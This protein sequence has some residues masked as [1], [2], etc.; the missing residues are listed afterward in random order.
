VPENFSS[1][2][3]VLAAEGRGLARPA[4]AGVIETYGRA[5][6]RRRRQLAAATSGLAVCAVATVVAVGF[7]GTRSTKPAPVVPGPVPTSQPSTISKINQDT[8]RFL[9]GSEAPD[10]GAYQWRLGAVRSDHATDT[11][12]PICLSG[13]GGQA[14]Q[15][16]HSQSEDL[17][18][19]SSDKSSSKAYES[20]FHYGSAAAARQDYNLLKPDPTKSSGLEKCTYGDT[21]GSVTDGFAW[22]QGSSSQ[23]S[24]HFLVVLSGNDI[25]F[26]RYQ[27]QGGGIT[28]DTSDDQAALQR[29]ADRLNGRVPVAE[30]ST[31]PLS[32]ALPDSA[33]LSPTQ[34]PFGT[35]DKSH[36][37]FQMPNQ[38][39]TH[40]DDPEKDLCASVYGGIV[41]SKE[42]TVAVRAY[43]GTP[44]DVPVYAGSNYLYSGANQD[45]ATFPTADKAKTAFEYAKQ[46]TKQVSCQF[47]DGS[48][49]QTARTLK[50][51]AVTDSGFSVLADDNSGSSYMHVYFVLKGT[52]V[53]TLEVD[54][55]KG[56]TST[57][58][59]AAVLAAM[60]ARLP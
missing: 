51:G 60:A 55:E 25:A 45:I 29:M 24:E 27:S 59:D 8:T 35:A 26:W 5:R 9:L 21:T 30:P 41:N 3:E 12:Y 52:H 16:T 42:A 1:L 54:F 22:A 15:A 23:T 46:V 49:E 44:T 37:W 31:P 18:E 11:L 32:T 43:H 19:Y 48:G 4:A 33:W 47:K 13:A 10:P 7:G 38:Q 40:G 17:A 20:I 6:R 56:D 53:A 57:S 28:Y 36:G 39:P 58:G 14:P 50:V 34:I 2:L